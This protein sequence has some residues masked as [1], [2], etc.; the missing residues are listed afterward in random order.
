M[1]DEA[2]QDRLLLEIV[3]WEGRMVLLWQDLGFTS[4]PRDTDRRTERG[5][6]FLALGEPGQFSLKLVRL[7]GVS[8]S[9]PADHQQA[10]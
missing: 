8:L 2:A 10:T 6:D 3:L 1:Q 4:E 5:A 7:G 9:H